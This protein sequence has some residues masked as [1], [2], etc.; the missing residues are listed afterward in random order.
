M[1]RICLI[2]TRGVVVVVGLQSISAGNPH[3]SGSTVYRG[4]DRTISEIEF[5]G[6]QRLPCRP[7]LMPREQRH[8]PLWCRIV[9]WLHSPFRRRSHTSVPGLG[10]S[11]TVALSRARLASASFNLASNG[12]GVNREEQI[13]LLQFL[14]ILEV[15]TDQFALDACLDR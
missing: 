11:G 8:L 5:G 9:P 3:S 12:T 4:P 6:C 15:N 14:S 7:V 2:V 10:H 1:G 13:S